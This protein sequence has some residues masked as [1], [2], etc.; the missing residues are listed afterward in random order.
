MKAY[1]LVWRLIRYRSGLYVAD[2]LLWVVIGL[3]EL[4]P[5]LVTKAFFDN[6]TGATRLRVGMWGVGALM[7]TTTIVN[8]GAMC[9]G[10]LVDA[11]YRFP[12]GT[13]LDRY[14]LER[15][16]NR[17]AGRAVPGSPGEAISVF[18]DDVSTVEEAVG[19]LADQI[20]T[21]L[22]AGIALVVMLRIDARLAVSEADVREITP[23]ALSTATAPMMIVC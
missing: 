23:L 8:L 15:I 18:R 19:W 21:V 16:L 2:T 1:Q 13:L 11:L 7:L 5:G 3:V 17:P 12:V 14:M 10:T 9:G 6:L 22:C 4:V 20:G